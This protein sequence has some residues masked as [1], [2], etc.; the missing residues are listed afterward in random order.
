[1]LQ[2]YDIVFLKQTTPAVPLAKGTKGTILIVYRD[3]PPAY[4]VEFVDD[5][6]G[7]L[8]T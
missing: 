7:S 5:A 6:G 2:E 8:G 3:S 1:M 4:E